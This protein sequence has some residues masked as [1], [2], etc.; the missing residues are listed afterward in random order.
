MAPV[1]PVIPGAS[2]RDGS[3]GIFSGQKVAQ[4]ETEM[5]KSIMKSLRIPLDE[6]YKRMHYYRHNGGTASASGHFARLCKRGDR[7]GTAA[8][9]EDVKATKELENILDLEE[10]EERIRAKHVGDLESRVRWQEEFDR[11]LKLL[12][13]DF[14]LSEVPSCRLNHLDRMHSWFTEHGG[15][16]MRKVKPGPSYLTADRG[17]DMPAGSTKNIAARRGIGSLRLKE[18]FQVGTGGSRT[19]GLGGKMLS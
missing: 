7:G 9:L 5:E 14:E 16:Q 18:A 3:V 12:M 6:R 19:S 15:K 2:A 11:H 13:V 10:H 8:L 17:Q 1:L 4:E